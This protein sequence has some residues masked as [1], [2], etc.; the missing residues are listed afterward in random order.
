MGR[1]IVGSVGGFIGTAK[2]MTELAPMDRILTIIYNGPP[3]FRKATKINLVF[4]IG[5]CVLVSVN[6]VWLVVRNRRKEG[7]RAVRISWG[8]GQKQKRHKEDALEMITRTLSI[9]YDGSCST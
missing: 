5:V 2:P 4:S 3:R 9:H 8:G 7:E 6:R 1:G